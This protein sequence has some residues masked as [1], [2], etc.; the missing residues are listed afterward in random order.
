LSHRRDT[1]V[2]SPAMTPRPHQ[3][4]RLDDIVG[5][6]EAAEALGIDQETFRKWRRRFPDMPKAVKVTGGMGLW[7]RSE[8]LRWR[9]HGG[10]PKRKAPPAA[11][12]PSPGPAPGAE[13][14]RHL[15]S[16]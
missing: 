16:V 14:G 15:R 6:R 13:P 2:G 1:L 7:L 5:P 12:P 8:L 3:T 9:E 11:E 10:G 4:V